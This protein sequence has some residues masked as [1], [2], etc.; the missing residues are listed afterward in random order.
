MQATPDYGRKLTRQ[1]FEQAVVN[2][3]DNPRSNRSGYEGEHIRWRELNLTIDHRL[4]VDFPLAR[5]EALWRVQ[6]Q[7]EK[8][9][10]RFAAR[11]L[12]A[13]IV[14][15]LGSNRLANIVLK[16]YAQVLTADEM[17]AYFGQ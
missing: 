8:E 5:R 9:R 3:Y 12:L 4:G 10:L 7:V 14:V 16:E 17:R 1:E 15:R 2:L 6:Q 13:P 11:T